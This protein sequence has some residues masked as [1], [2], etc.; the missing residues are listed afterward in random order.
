MVAEV[1]CQ[2]VLQQA[3][4]GGVVAA[5]HGLHQVRHPA[6]LG[7]YELGVDT[8]KV[9]VPSEHKYKGKTVNPRGQESPRLSRGTSA[10]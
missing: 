1:T 4:E 3:L 5:L 8:L 9:C 2:Y 6:H 10:Q 7:G